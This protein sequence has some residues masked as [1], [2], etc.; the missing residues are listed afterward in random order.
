MKTYKDKDARVILLESA[1]RRKFY[2]LIERR[3]MVAEGARMLVHWTCEDSHC[4]GDNDPR[5]FAKVL[6]LVEAADKI[7]KE[8]RDE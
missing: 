1:T 4:H 3:P 7:A 8:K 2:N 6:A 5:H